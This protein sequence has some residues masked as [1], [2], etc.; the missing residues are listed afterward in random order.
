MAHL[1]TMAMVWHD[2]PVRLHTWPPTAVQIKEYVAT[3]NRH[4]SSTPALIPSGD[5]IPPSSPSEGGTQQQFR[6]ALRDLADAQ[7][8]EVLSEVCSETAKR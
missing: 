3:R 5:L 1:V 6:F 7:L 8:W 4:P 2:D